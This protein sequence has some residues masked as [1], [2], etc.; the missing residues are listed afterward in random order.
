MSHNDNQKALIKAY[1]NTLYKVFNPQIV[2]SVNNT[3]NEL[4][5]LLF[6]LN[7]T[8]WAYITPYNPFGKSY[9][10]EENEEF[11]NLMLQ[12]IKDYKYFIGEGQGIDTTWPPEKSV[13]I[14]GI[15]KAAAIQ[16]GN[17]YNQN[18]IV[19]GEKGDVAKLEFLTAFDLV[20]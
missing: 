11:F 14:V 4:K 13:L 15:S 9:T 7:K 17:K 5:T 18:A 3:S 19:V 1:E 16:L 10:D 2:I 12:D 6:N 20:K 8:E